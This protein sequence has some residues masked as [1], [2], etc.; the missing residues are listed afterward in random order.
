MK[1]K[2]VSGRQLATTHLLDTD[3]LR[4]ALGV[5]VVPGS[6]NVAL[7]RPYRFNEKSA[8]V[9]SGSAQRMFWPAK[10]NNTDI[11]LYRW[12]GCP[13]SVVELVAPYHIRS[14]FS[15]S[16][17]DTVKITVDD[18]IL[19]PV[20]RFSLLGWLLLWAGRSKYYYLTTRYANYAAI[21]SGYFG[22]NQGC[23]SDRFM[24]A[25]K[26]GFA[27]VR[28]WAANSR[29]L[30]AVRR[31]LTSGSGVSSVPTALTVRQDLPGK[32]ATRR[33]IELVQLT[34]LLGYAKTELKSYSALLF[35]A[36]Y[37]T[38]DVAGT[39]L[40]GQRKPKDRLALL[41]FDLKGASVLDIGCNQGGMLFAAADSGLRWGVG[42][43]HDVKLLNAA[44]RMRTIRGDAR[45]SF[46]HFD[47]DKEDHGRILDFLPDENVDLVLLLSVCMW[48]TQ[49][50]ALL[51]FCSALSPKLLFETN[52]TEQQQ[53]EQERYVR[54]LYTHIEL[55][56]GESLDDPIQKKRR[57][58]YCERGQE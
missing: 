23:R 50:K 38:L 11:Y 28:G 13:L 9:L 17:G 52:G 15:L 51:D 49:W 1:G 19:I 56:A 22:T 44:N 24:T 34:N 33:E 37:H 21:L 57:L 26:R 29:R 7:D 8:V 20:G 31:A 40:P 3:D 30:R 48:I 14:T 32:T 46:Y 53:S 5:A 35:P 41:P 43:D 42:I 36:G 4:V 6:L 58:F 12:R 16:D 10:L 45:I 18:Q 54:K 39:I 27:R 55:L 2:I 25:L 47:V